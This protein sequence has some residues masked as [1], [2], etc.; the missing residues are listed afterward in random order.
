V[1]G[2]GKKEKA[3]VA[4][5]RNRYSREI[6]DDLSQNLTAIGL[7]LE[8]CKHLI[9]K[10]PEKAKEI[11]ADCLKILEQSS[12][13]LKYTVFEPAALINSGLTQYI[14]KQIGNLPPGI[15]CSL[16]VS[17]EEIIFSP[18]T[19]LLLW[20]IFSE[21]FSFFGAENVENQRENLNLEIIFN[22]SEP[23]FIILKITGV[24][25]DLT[26]NNGKQSKPGI[27][28]LIKKTEECGL[29]ITLEKNHYFTN[30]KIN[31]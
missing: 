21:I 4:E 31:L 11:L 8:F 27:A 6:H 12:L 30:I 9:E 20:R 18:K 17:G 2:F 1:K 7:N 22:F 25:I 14:K 28:G 3:L 26:V 23:S 29:K 13:E 5:E 16:T 24:N 15:K 10:Q 19:E